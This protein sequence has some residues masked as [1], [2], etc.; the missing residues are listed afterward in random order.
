MYLSVLYRH[1]LE[2]IRLTYDS[3]YI[4]GEGAMLTF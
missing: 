2:G 1:A 4:R 3:K